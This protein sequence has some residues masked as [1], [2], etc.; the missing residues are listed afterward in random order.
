[1]IDSWGCHLTRRRGY[2]NSTKVG[3]EGMGCWLMPICHHFMSRALVSFL[4][5]SL[6]CVCPSFAGLVKCEGPTRVIVIFDNIFSL[7]GLVLI[8]IQVGSFE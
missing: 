8:I 7:L 2:Y 6:I 4:L 3:G 5:L 1:M